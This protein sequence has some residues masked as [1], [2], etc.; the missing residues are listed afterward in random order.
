MG[1]AIQ[2]AANKIPLAGFYNNREHVQTQMI[3]A[4]RT[5]MLSLGD[6]I[7][8]KWFQL[9]KVTL[10]AATEETVVKSVIETE[11]AKTQNYDNE[12]NV[13]VQKLAVI[14]GQAK[15]QI[16]TKLAEANAAASIK[17]QNATA[18]AVRVQREAETKAIQDL[19]SKIGLKN[20]QMMRYLWL[21]EIREQSNVDLIVGLDGNSDVL[22]N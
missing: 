19:K 5:K 18:Q 13:I 14:Q 10:P 16:N 6:F 11:R 7:D 8:V 1:E 17:R 9:R 12:R 22:I 15:A 2:N 4:V 3:E 21:K 20:N